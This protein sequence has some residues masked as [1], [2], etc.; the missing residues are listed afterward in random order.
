MQEKEL[1]DISSKADLLGN[2][3]TSHP[4]V[5]L[6]SPRPDFFFFSYLCFQNEGPEARQLLAG[7]RQMGGLRREPGPSVWNV[8]VLAHL[9]PHF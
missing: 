2:V 9:L 4:R 5:L 8:G 6:F 3:A 1:Y 7:D